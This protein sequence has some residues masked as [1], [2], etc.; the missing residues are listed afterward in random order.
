[1]NGVGLVEV[2][3]ALVESPIQ[4]AVQTL[5]VSDDH[6]K[7]GLYGILTIRITSRNAMGRL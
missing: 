6:G 3:T 5:F 4:V 1:M 7:I 2:H